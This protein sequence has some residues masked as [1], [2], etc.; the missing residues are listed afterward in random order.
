MP[1]NMLSVREAARAMGVSPALVYQLCAEG[2]LPHYRLGGRGRRGKIVIDPA[3]LDA[4]FRARRV[5]PE[6]PPHPPLGHIS[7]G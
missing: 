5:E 1:G 6:A 3:E 2:M 7:L 4:Y